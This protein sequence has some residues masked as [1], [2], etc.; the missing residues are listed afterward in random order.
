M[1]VTNKTTFPVIVVC[2]HRGHGYGEEETIQPGETAEVL[3]PY[4]GMMG[5][6]HCHVEVP[7]E[8]ICHEDPDDEDERYHVSKGNQLVLSG[9]ER[10]TTVRHHEE[11]IKFQKEA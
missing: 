7:G 8:I 3:G 6:G 5:V 2:W 4:L 11:E 10:G 1:K 9:E